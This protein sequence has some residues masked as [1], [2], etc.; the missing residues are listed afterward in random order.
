MIRQLEPAPLWNH[1]ADLNA[2]PRPSY[3]EAAVIEFIL[4]FG[5]KLGLPT[6]RDRAGNV[7]IEKPA[8]GRGM[9]NRKTVILQGHL[10]M[11]CE[12][13]THPHFKNGV[14]MVVENGWVSAPGSTLG[15][16]NGIGVAAAMAL[17]S[18]REIDHPPL[19]GLFTITEE[20]GLT[21]ARLL[22]PRLVRKGDILLNMDTEDDTELCISCAGAIGSSA[23]VSYKPEA[24]TGD[25]V[26]FKI[27]VDGLTGG[28]SGV[29][30][31]KHR[32][33]ANKLMT[34]LFWPISPKI[35]LRLAEMVN[36][37][38]RNVIP[39][40]S[41]AT[42]GVK[43]G[44]ADFFKNEF[45]KRA[46]DLQKEWAATEPGLRFSLE[47][48]TE[49]PA[50]L[51]PAAVQK[52]LFRALSACPNGVFRMSPEV[53]GLVET[54]SNLAR[55]VARDGQIEVISL[56]RS[57]RESGKTEV[58]ESVRA[59][60]E[61]NG[62]RIKNGDDYPGWTPNPASPIL[63]LAKT[64][65]QQVFEK[66]AHVVNVHAGLECGVIVEK[67]A[68]LNVDAL[69]FGPNIRGAHSPGERCEVVSVQKFWRFLLAL[70][71]Q[72]PVK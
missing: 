27:T 48:T 52:R 71:A 38:A 14:S 69:S 49:K 2:I 9:K 6:R 31:D 45:E 4:D 55:V 1:F 37:S 40:S 23:T 13:P 7:V 10:D 3:G 44:Q 54:S 72:T 65:F 32:G 36:D 34:R 20:T 53:E 30:I 59:A 42:V 47:K 66:E 70:L 28:H 60:F 26:F 17:L 64:V 16:D 43:I 22:D 15:A 5:K 68:R 61:S 57:S 24:P 39:R 18:S 56:Q 35:G 41:L 62:F 21:G 25:L 67:L 33:N 46:A 58:A 11:V 12:P 51:L 50:G 8:H 63:A 19:V 29:D